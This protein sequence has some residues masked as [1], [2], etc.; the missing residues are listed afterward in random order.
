MGGIGGFIFSVIVTIIACA[1]AYYYLHIHPEGAFHK[2][3]SKTWKEHKKPEA[4][5]NDG[6]DFWD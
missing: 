2:S 4:E 1:I 5:K 3:K 6:K